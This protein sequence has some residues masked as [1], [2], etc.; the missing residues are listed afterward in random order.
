MSQAAFTQL[1]A[2]LN[3]AAAAISPFAANSRYAGI[4]VATTTDVDGRQLV[5]LT[6]RFLPPL[7]GF[8]FVG[9]H[10]VAAAERPDL[11]AQ[12]YFGDPLQFWQ[13]CDANGVMNPPDLTATPGVVVRI[14]LPLGIGGTQ[15][16]RTR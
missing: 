14:N 11:L 13:L 4:P 10:R 2:V 5:Y 8:S 15:I 1:S 6:R 9:T 16:G 7:D 3:P 12:T